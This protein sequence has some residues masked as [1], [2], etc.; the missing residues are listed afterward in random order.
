VASSRGFESDAAMSSHDLMQ[1]IPAGIVISI[2]LEISPDWGSFLAFDHCFG[3][4]ALRLRLFFF[5]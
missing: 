4:F 5:A 1:N 2:Q 3:E